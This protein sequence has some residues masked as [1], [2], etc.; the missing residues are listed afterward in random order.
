MGQWVG[1]TRPAG[2]VGG[3]LHLV[4]AEVLVS[5]VFEPAAELLGAG[6]SVSGIG[7]DFGGAKDFLGDKDGAVGA[8]GEGHIR[9]GYAVPVDAIAAGLKALQACLHSMPHKSR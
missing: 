9:F 2:A 1:P 3:Q 6:L 7:Q 5:E 8:Q 4:F